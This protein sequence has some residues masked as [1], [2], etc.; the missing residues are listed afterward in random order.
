MSRKDVLTRKHTFGPTNHNNP[1]CRKLF[2][3]KCSHIARGGFYCIFPSDCN[4]LVVVSKRLIE[5][6]RG[7][8]ER[9]RPFLAYTSHFKIKLS[10]AAFSRAT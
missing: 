6:N 10:C 2:L 3:P 4:R 8:Q 9:G 7:F 5:I 1:D